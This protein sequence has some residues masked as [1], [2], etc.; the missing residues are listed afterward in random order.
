MTDTTL[1]YC[2][3]CLHRSLRMGKCLQ[4]GFRGSGTA[5]LSVEQ[6]QQLGQPTKPPVRSADDGDSG[7][8][9]FD[10]FDGGSADFSPGGE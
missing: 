10:L 8:C 1:Q 9:D 2:P 7:D 3:K 4:C 6:R 5:R